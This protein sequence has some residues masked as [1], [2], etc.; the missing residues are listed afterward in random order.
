MSVKVLYIPK[1]FV[2]PPKKKQI[3]GY[4]PDLRDPE[5]VASELSMYNFRRQLKTPLSA[6]Y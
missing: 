4:A 5:V 1:T 6:Q 2:P 3:S